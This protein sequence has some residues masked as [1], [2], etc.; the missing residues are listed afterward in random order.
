MNLLL[1]LTLPL[2]SLALACAAHAQTPFPLGGYFNDP[3][4]SDSGAEAQFEANY[5][6]FTQ[7]MGTAPQFLVRYTDFSQP[8][9]AW[10]GNAAWTAWSQ[11]QS[12]AKNAIPVIGI[13]LASTASGSASL[14]QQYRAFASGSYDDA[15]TGVVAAWQQH[16]FATQYWRIGYEMNADN[17]GGSRSYAGQ[18][19][20]TEAD[21]VAA[22]QH[23]ATILRQ[24][25]NSS[26][27][28]VKIVWNPNVTNYDKTNTL[29]AL[30]PG[31]AYVDVI[32]A[33][34][35]G[36]MWPYDLYDWS[37]NDGT[38]DSS[39]TQWVA[40][41]ANR[42]HYWTYPEATQGSL[43]SSGGRNLSLQVL[44]DF[45]KA[46]GK[47]FA[48]PETGAGNSNGGHDVSDEGAFPQWL[49]QTL[50]ASGDSIAFVNLWDS[51]ADGN[52]LFSTSDAN[53]PNEAAAWARYFGAASTTGFSSTGFYALVNTN[54]GSCVDDSGWSTANGTP[55]VQWQCG[56]Q[57]NQQWQLRPTD[58]GYYSVVSRNAAGSV[59]DA[60]NGGTGNGTAIQLYQ[61][62]GYN[63]QQWMPVSLGNG[64]Y[65]LVGR[66]SGRCLDVPSAS[67][68]DGVRMQIWDCNGTG[69][70]SF[71]LTV[72]P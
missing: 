18:D 58:S 63:N 11:Q 48:V 3:N 56:Q 34:I 36:D 20:A 14:D 61:N 50:K 57:A 16:G 51:N 38:V 53:K 65:K 29:S 49:A 25:G 41:P 47:P 54:S 45:A 13:G 1:R 43:D 17:G 22:F 8:V 42:T 40:D 19:A 24:A 46:H 6:S 60:V 31:D 27:T 52:F 64:A 62:Y 68:A 7:L 2:A 26:G 37:K 39:F 21:W 67:T 10:A 5:S 30:Y 23:V 69:A 4:G 12:P 55:I 28:V 72:A 35:Y 71:R 44:L 33:D 70:Q 32:G 66:A 59:L 9:S 15:I